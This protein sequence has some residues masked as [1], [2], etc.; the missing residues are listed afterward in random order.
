MP[1]AQIDWHSI[2][3][4]SSVRLVIPLEVIEELDLLKFDRRRPDG[5]RRILPQLAAVLGAGGEP[6]EGREDTTIEV[7]VSP[8]PRARPA[9]GDEEVLQTCQE[10]DQFG[11]RPVTLISADTAIRLRAQAWASEQSRCRADT[12]DRPTTRE[13]DRPDHGCW[14]SI[15]GPAV[16]SGFV[17]QLR[18]VRMPPRTL[19]RGR[20]SDLN[21]FF[22]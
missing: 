2:L 8:A 10:L 12:H 15:K 5:A 9:D 20:S 21:P 3:A 19:A 7:L 1:P 13:P 16:C 17:A 11:G 6:R 22:A 14:I 18:V 4:I